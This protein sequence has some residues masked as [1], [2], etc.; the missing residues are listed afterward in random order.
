MNCCKMIVLN[1]LQLWRFI[2]YLCR[3]PV[4]I[5]FRIKG[6]HRRVEQACKEVKVQAHSL[7]L[8]F[9]RYIDLKLFP[10][11]KTLA[12]W[13][14]LIILTQKIITINLYLYQLLL[15]CFY[16][17]YK[18]HKATFLPFILCWHQMATFQV[19]DPGSGAFLFPGS[20]IVSGSWIP[21]PKPI[22]LRA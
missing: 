1:A 22:F 5:A 21:D 4:V 12:P 11:T 16:I 20:G 19:A 18:T 3:S 15:H 9:Y 17:C 7:A 13:K 6:L 10:F 8:T 14:N 2:K